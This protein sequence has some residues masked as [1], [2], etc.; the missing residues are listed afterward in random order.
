M[1]PSCAPRSLNLSDSCSS[2][3]SAGFRCVTDHDHGR[4]PGTIART[5]RHEHDTTP[6]PTRTDARTARPTNLPAVRNDLLADRSR[7]RRRPA[8][9]VQTVPVADRRDRGDSMITTGCTDPVFSFLS[10]SR[11]TGGRTGETAEA[12]SVGGTAVRGR[13][14]FPS[15]SPTPHYY[16]THPVWCGGGGNHTPCVVRFDATADLDRDSETAATVTAALDSCTDRRGGCPSTLPLV[17]PPERK[18]KTRVVA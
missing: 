9:R 15:S 5:E 16:T 7:A 2:R 6:D 18:Q 14:H 11:A 3:L 12:A 1:F 13:V 8:R 17:R 4:D 10:V